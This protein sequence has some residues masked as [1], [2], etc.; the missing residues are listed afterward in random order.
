MNLKL[1]NLDE[2][3][4]SKGD[5]SEHDREEEESLKHEEHGLSCR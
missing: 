5:V 4:E 3:P 1:F 2:L